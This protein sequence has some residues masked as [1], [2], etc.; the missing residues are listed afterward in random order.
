MDVD[1]STAAASVGWHDAYLRA[2]HREGRLLTD[3][4][5]AGLPRVPDDHPLRREWRAREDSCARLVRYLRAIPRPLTL[6]EAGCGNG[7]LA[8][9]IA[10]ITGVEV[11]GVDVNA[12]E[13]DQ[14][15]R[16]FGGL[17]NL[18]FRNADILADPPPVDGAG[19]VVLAS[20]IQY[21]PD[22]ASLV[23]RLLDRSRA[24]AEVHVLD[25]PVYD[26]AE[27]A[28]AR[29]STERHYAAIGVP[30]MARVYHHHTWDAFAGLPMDVLYRPGGPWRW[31]ERH[32]LRCA[33]SPFPWLRF[34]RREA[35]S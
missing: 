13:L 28:C 22:P 18:T 9:R 15:R 23:E 31:V 30:E 3:A 33:R 4:V 12:V 29:E 20:V 19:V 1:I 5:V 21:A 26:T 32:A 35:G 7:W 27:V 2:R 25:S 14:A 24:T 34:M 16:V 6:L 8:A 17:S 11:V 10:A